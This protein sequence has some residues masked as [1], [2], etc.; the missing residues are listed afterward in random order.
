MTSRPGFR[1]QAALL[2]S[3]AI[4]CTLL[5]VSACRKGE[6]AATREGSPATAAAPAAPKINASAVPAAGSPVAAKVTL[7]IGAGSGL[8]NP[9]SVA[10]DKAGNIYVADS[11]HGRIVKFDPT[12]REL[13]KFG[14]KG[15][16]PGDFS[17]P[18]TIGVSQQGN[19]LVHERES[20][21]VQCFTPDGKY[22]SRFGGTG[23]GLYFS[24]GMAV[25]ANGTPLVAD[26]ANNRVVLLG[27]EGKPPALSIAKVGGESLNQPPE[28]AVDPSGNLLVLGLG[29][30]GNKGHLFKLN[31]AGELQAGWIVLGV[32]TTRDTP[33]IAVAP[34]GRLVVTDPEE[35]RVVVYAANMSTVSP[36]GLEGELAAPLRVPSGIAVDPQGR[37]YVVD[38]EANLV[39]RFELGKG[40]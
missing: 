16:N 30:P 25:T 4:S 2:V 33:R 24:G 20:Q 36:V 9:R 34:D 26:T 22:V 6:P 14:Q 3:I 27:E 28:V 11:G 5:S 19:V 17:E 10:I 40:N 8:L 29:G 18:W 35:R 13:L 31:P 1:R 15:K 21:F 39:Y 7:R 38:V 23:P 32:P 37:F 12:G